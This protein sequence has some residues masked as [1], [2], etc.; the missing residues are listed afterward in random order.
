MII[1]ANSPLHF[2]HGYEFD[3]RRILTLPG[4]V[5]AQAE[6]VIT[7]NGRASLRQQLVQAALVLGLISE[8]F[9]VFVGLGW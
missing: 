6:A 8:L 1:H 3:S 2:G 9:V 7:R 4:D 5:A